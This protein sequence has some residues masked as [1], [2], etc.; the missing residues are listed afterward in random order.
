MARTLY[1]ILT[2]LAVTGRIRGIQ[3]QPVRKFFVWRV[4]FCH[5]FLL[6]LGRSLMLENL[7]PSLVRIV[8][9]QLVVRH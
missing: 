6:S 2:F 3:K 9:L 1:S 7:R 5:S 8:S 4:I